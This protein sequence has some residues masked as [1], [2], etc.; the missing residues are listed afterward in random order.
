MRSKRWK[1]FVFFMFPLPSND[2]EIV[3]DF[4]WTKMSEIFG[5]L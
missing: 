2:I 4:A 5:F 3:G 1:E